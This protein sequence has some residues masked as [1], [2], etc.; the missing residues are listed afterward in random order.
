MQSSLAT[1][2][3]AAAA[4]EDEDGNVDDKPLPTTENASHVCIF[5]IL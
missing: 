5:V 2:D 1:T 4:D 3:A